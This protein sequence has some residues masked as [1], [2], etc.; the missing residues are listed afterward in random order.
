MGYKGGRSAR[1]RQR[2]FPSTWRNGGV[3]QFDRTVAGLRIH[4]ID[5]PQT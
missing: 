1:I 3:W 2:F 5:C 4:F